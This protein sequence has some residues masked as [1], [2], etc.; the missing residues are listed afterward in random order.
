MSALKVGWALCGSFCTFDRVMPVMERLAAS[1]A[2]VTPIFS[3]NAGK[4]DTRFGSAAGWI[5]RAEQICGKKAILS[6][7]DAEPIG[8]GGLFDI[9]IVA[10]ATGN[11][12]AKLAH[13]VTDTSVTMACKSHL[14]GGRPVLIALS[15]NDGLSGSAANIGSLMRRKNIFF[16]PFRQD[17][18]AKKP[19]SLSADMESIP[20][21]LPA[22]MRGEQPGLAINS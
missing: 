8:P 9:L 22:V 16:V 5:A 3:E 21:L 14:R 17:D 15:T 2:E 13:A 18:P 7:V 11:T 1:G 12:L 10:P 4:T 20:E 19:Y 6:I